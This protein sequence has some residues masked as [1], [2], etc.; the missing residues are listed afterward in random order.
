MS[1]ISDLAVQLVD[2]ENLDPECMTWVDS[3]VQ[4]NTEA[5]HKQAIVAVAHDDGTLL[6]LVVKE[7][8]RCGV[9]EQQPAIHDLHTLMCACGEWPGRW[10]A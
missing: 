8:P 9:C 3:A 10:D 1:K 2:V 7:A 5:D 6:F 4:L